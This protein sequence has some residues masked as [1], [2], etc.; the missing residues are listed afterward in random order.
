[1]MEDDGNSRPLPRTFA[2]FNTSATEPHIFYP[3][4][5][6][7]SNNTNLLNS[8]R[9]DDWV[10]RDPQLSRKA[11]RLR[12]LY[13]TGDITTDPHLSSRV[14]RTPD[15]GSKMTE[16]LLRANSNIVA[17][18]RGNL[19]NGER[20]AASGDEKSIRRRRTMAN[21]DSSGK[22]KTTSSSSAIVVE[23]PFYPA[24]TQAPINSLS[25]NARYGANTSREGFA[26]TQDHLLTYDAE[27][28]ENVNVMESPAVGLLTTSWSNIGLDKAAKSRLYAPI[29]HAASR[30][31]IAPHSERV[32][33]YTKLAPG[34]WG[35]RGKFPQ[36][37]SLNR[38]LNV[39]GG[40]KGANDDD[41]H[42]MI[43]RGIAR[44]IEREGI[45]QTRLH[46]E[47]LEKRRADAKAHGRWLQGNNAATANNAN[48]K[49]GG[50]G[51][52]DGKMKRMKKRGS[53]KEGKGTNN[54][55]NSTNRE[56]GEKSFGTAYANYQQ[57]DVTS[58]SPFLIALNGQKASK[59]A[60]KLIKAKACGMWGV[61]VTSDDSQ[62]QKKKF[63]T[64]IA[65]GHKQ[66]LLVSDLKVKHLAK[67]AIIMCT[68]PNNS[69]GFEVVVLI[70]KA[71]VKTAAENP[72]PE[73]VSREQFVKVLTSVLAHVEQRFANSLYS[74]FDSSNRQKVSQ[75][76]FC[77]ALL[78]VHRPSMNNLVSGKH[79]VG[80]QWSKS[81]PIIER[82]IGLIKN[83]RSGIKA[84]ELRLI[85]RS[86]TLTS[87]D[88]RQIDA[89][90]D[91]AFKDGF[92]RN[93]SGFEAPELLDVADI[94]GRE[95]STL[96]RHGYVLDEFQKQLFALQ[97]KVLKRMAIK[98][99]EEEVSEDESV[100]G[101]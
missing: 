12:G 8:L 36:G 77:C 59:A 6:T 90:L 80:R 20:A 45:R 30:A 94:F 76:D 7:M 81:I 21:K 31:I 54:N 15:K 88:R 96:I 57:L 97:E 86:V 51:R 24:Y 14:V 70:S 87:D 22:G 18:A 85:I 35:D 63:G 13:N 42:F 67:L 78:C 38:G 71:L 92:K 16:A 33:A 10:P 32:D 53:N 4:G 65:L 58:S 26:R 99:G 19:P 73:F 50:G 46:N 44:V 27:F 11:R 9:R 79:S 91:T 55:N 48:Q 23:R 66:L 61:V 40:N 41:D 28:Y 83:G 68:A 101:D 93:G 1:M 2:A 72:D 95:E 52:G 98:E 74:S 62:E 89:R 49:Q 75:I 39:N 5:K 100:D 69:P 47:A 25:L 3:G 56:E 37:S 64:A 29:A 17:D 60:T 43:P 82:G 84:S 34:T